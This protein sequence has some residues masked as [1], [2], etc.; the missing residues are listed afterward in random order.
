MTQTMPI[1]P[2]IQP[3]LDH[4]ANGEVRLD[5]P[6]VRLDMPDDPADKSTPKKH[7]RTVCRMKMKEYAS[8]LTI[9]G[10]TRVIYGCKKEKV[11]N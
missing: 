3:G 2:H 6:D 4:H 8:A 5:M 7:H 9:H 10:V 11:M 1:Y